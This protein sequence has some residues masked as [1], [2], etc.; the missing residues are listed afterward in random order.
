[1]LGRIN[2][3]TITLML[4]LVCSCNTS[5][6]A[7][8]QAYIEEQYQH[9][10]TLIDSGSYSFVATA[11]F[12]LQTNA[13][14]EA[15]QNLFRGT[16]NT[17]TRIVLTKNDAFINVQNDS[18]IGHLSYYGE[19]RTANYSDDRDTAIIFTGKPQSYEV[20]ENDRKN[21]MEIKLKV[22]SSTEQFNLKMDVYHNSRVYLL[23]SGANRT[24][25][26]YEGYLRANEL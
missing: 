11:A 9:V 16:D 15:T 24:A 18:V 22:K 7:A 13:V 3:L 25:I 4:L 2:I 21:S 20:V 6:S 23:V 14:T 5:R 12:P 10:K 8:E 17:G 26:R 19:L 1:M